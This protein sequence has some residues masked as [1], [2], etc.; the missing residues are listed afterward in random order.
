[1]LLSAGACSNKLLPAGRGSARHSAMLW[2]CA[3]GRRL[4]STQPGVPA[5]L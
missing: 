3:A 1:M 4:P 2:G 5:C